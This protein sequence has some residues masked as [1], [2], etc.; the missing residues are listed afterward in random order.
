MIFK[1]LKYR[2]ELVRT[3][4]IPL[5]G[6]AISGLVLF[7]INLLLVNIIGEVLT[8]LGGALIYTV[9]YMILLIF[10]R[11][12]KTHELHKIPF[13]RLFVGLSEKIQKELIYEE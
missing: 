5:I 13:G 3:F 8:M 7:L 9:L 6:A 4:C 2:Q 1:M 10:L 11:G 12:I